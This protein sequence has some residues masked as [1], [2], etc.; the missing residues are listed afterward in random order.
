MLQSEVFCY[1]WKLKMKVDLGRRIGELLYEH[2]CV[3]IPEFGGFVA[4]VVPS[5]LDKQSNTIL[6]PSKQ[7]SFNQNLTHNDGLLANHLSRKQ[8]M[9][10]SEAVSYLL[11]QADKYRNELK[12]GNRIEL[13]SIGV[14]YRD[15]SGN[16]RFVPDHNSNHYKESFGLGKL[17]LTPVVKEEVEPEVEEAVIAPVEEETPVVT[18]ENP[19]ARKSRGWVAAAAIIVP[20]ALVGTY[21]LSDSMSGGG[22]LDLA[23]L[24]PF[25]SNEAIQA[26]FEPRFEEENIQFDYPADKNTIEE[27]TQVN[28]DLNTVYFSFEEDKIEPNGI[29]IIL[30]ENAPESPEPVSESPELST[31]PAASKLKMWFVVGG[32]FREPSN[33]E[34][35]VSTLQQKGYESYVFGNSNGLHLVC[36]GSYTNKAAAKEALAKVKSEENASAWL[37][38]H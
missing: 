26:D 31:P 35:L 2:D 18:I 4:K 3:I 12:Q 34:G 16:I 15:Q 24:N 32:A 14:I 1:I 22:Q 28:P 37:K 33:A 30:R 27:I 36:Y 25:K 10:Y 23:S 20:L 6:P 5:Q 9:E 8:G 13:N 21:L 29:E 7:L 19:P 38:K 11:V 17:Y